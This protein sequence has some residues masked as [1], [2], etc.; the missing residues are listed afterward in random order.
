MEVAIPLLALGGI[1]V[2]SNQ[3]KKETTHNKEEKKI[4]KQKLQQENFT[5]MGKNPNYLPNLIEPPQNYPVL[6]VNES[7]DIALNKYPNPIQ[8]PTSILIKTFMKK[9]LIKELVLDEIHKKF[10]L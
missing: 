8:Q 4:S 3:K 6:N 2:V 7:I 1:Y 5:N 9:M 10:I